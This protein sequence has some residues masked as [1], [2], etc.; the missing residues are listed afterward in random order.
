[1]FGRDS[2]PY[3]RYFVYALAYWWGAKQVRSGNYTVLDFFIVLPALLFSAQASGQLFALAPEA[4]RAKGAAASIFALHDQKPTI[5]QDYAEKSDTMME[6]PVV[7]LAEVERLSNSSTSTSRGQLE[8]RNV[9]LEYPTRPDRPVLRGLNLS[10]S[11]GEFVAF[12]G[13]SGA[14]KSSAI[15]LVERFFDPTSGSLLVDGADIR[16]MPVEKHRERLSI[17]SQEPDLFS[18]SVAFNVGLGAK[19]GTTASQ[20]EI[21]DVCRKCGIHDFVMGLPNGYMTLVFLS[22]NHVGRLFC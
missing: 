13:P 11:P 4:T 9:C 17:V 7:E 2:C 16:S 10:V 22:L 15:S 5:I 21:E 3:D 8:F 6:K 12:V 19:P 20:E 1:M 18:G 14:G